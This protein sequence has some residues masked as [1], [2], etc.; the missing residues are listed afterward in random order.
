VV[1]AAPLRRPVV[2]RKEEEMKK[3]SASSKKNA[4]VPRKLLMAEFKRSFDVR[5]R[6]GRAA[7]SV[8]QRALVAAP[9]WSATEYLP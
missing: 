4:G 2:F 8:A 9:R 6:S 1:Y 7:T 5:G 3:E